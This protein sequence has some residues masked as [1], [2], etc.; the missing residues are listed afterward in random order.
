MNLSINDTCIKL[1]DRPPYDKKL[2]VLGARNHSALCQTHLNSP[3]GNSLKMGLYLIVYRD[4]LIHLS[5]S[6]NHLHHCQHPSYY[7]LLRLLNIVVEKEKEGKEI[8]PEILLRV[9]EV[10]S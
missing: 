7:Q 4:Y 8:C 1:A 10:E 6:M 3:S 5:S 9:A 2:P